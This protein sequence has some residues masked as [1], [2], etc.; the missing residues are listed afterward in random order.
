[1]TI[2]QPGDRCRSVAVVT[3]GFACQ[4]LG[5]TAL[6]KKPV[7]VAYFGRS[8]GCIA[9]PTARQVELIERLSVLCKS[10]RW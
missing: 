4:G 10:C 7:F 1:M 3:S 5:A 6:L 8:L 9:W 2:G